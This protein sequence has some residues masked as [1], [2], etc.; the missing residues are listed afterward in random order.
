MQRT[1][2][3]GGTTVTEKF[4]YTYLTTGDN[5]G[6]VSS[7]VLRRKDQDDVDWTTV[8]KAEYAYYGAS[9]NHGNAFDLKTVTVK[10]AS[11]N[12]LGTTYYRYYKPEDSDGYEHGLM[13]VFYPESYA[14]L[15]AEVAADPTTATDA[16]VAPYADHY[17]E[18]DDQQRATKE[19]A[20]GA[21]CSSCSGGQASPSISPGMTTLAA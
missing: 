12:V 4:T 8:R 19:I 7:V 9:E 10:D 18:Y 6:H 20:Q 11:N 17:F 21:G 14:R 15:V 13:Y 1:S 3:V 5:I 2:T 16:A